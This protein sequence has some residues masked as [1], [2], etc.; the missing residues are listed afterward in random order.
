MTVPKFTFLV[1]DLI[2]LI[3]F[4]GFINIIFDLNRLLFIGEFLILGVLML[5]ALISMVSVY[6]DIRFG[7]SLLSFVFALV[8]IDL[9][10]I[11]L[12]KSPSSNLFLITGILGLVGFII[13]ITNTQASEEVEEEHT[14]KTNS[15]VKKEFKPG[16]F[17][18]S[19]TGKKYH[20][21]KCDWAKKIKKSNAVWFNSKEAAKKAGYKK[22]DCVK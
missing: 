4:V 13:S 1:V 8:L 15:N 22:D 6:N 17:I 3:M 9:F 18:A 2:L 11:Y 19:K 7:W 5:I 10:F 14:K 20:A 12:I 16:K 21:P